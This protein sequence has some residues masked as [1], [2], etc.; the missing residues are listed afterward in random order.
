MF[1]AI[2]F[3]SKLTVPR[4]EIEDLLEQWF[5][6]QGEVTG[7][8]GGLG[9]TNIDIE[10]DDELGVEEVLSR[11]RDVLK[12]INAAPNTEIMVEDQTYPL[13]EQGE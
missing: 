12:R 4:D 5:A 7:S 3:N 13:Y 9:G 10:A 1:V 2:Y 6:G 11:I 8:G